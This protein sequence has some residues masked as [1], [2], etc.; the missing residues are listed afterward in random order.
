MRCTKTMKQT[1]CQSAIGSEI[2]DHRPFFATQ[3]VRTGDLS[4]SRGQLLGKT[5]RCPSQGRLGPSEPSQTHRRTYAQ[6]PRPLTFALPTLLVAIG[7]PGEVQRCG[8]QCAGGLG[9]PGHRRKAPLREG[10]VQALARSA[11][12][13]ILCLADMSHSILSGNVRHRFLLPHPKKGRCP[14]PGKRCATALRGGASAGPKSS[15]AWCSRSP[16]PSAAVHRGRLSRQTWPCTYRV[17]PRRS[18]AAGTHRPS[19]SIDGFGQILNAVQRLRS[20][21][22]WL[23]FHAR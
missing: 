20:C 14:L 12:A 15:P 3:S 18:R 7:A 1:P 23:K 5:A 8:V 2:A 11:L 22:G 21:E 9:E 10:V 17:P 19:P 6:T 4:G 13:R 16:T